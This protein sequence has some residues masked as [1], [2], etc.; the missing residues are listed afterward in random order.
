LN[1]AL[2]PTETPTS[3]LAEHSIISNMKSTLM[4]RY[5]TEFVTNIP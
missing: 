1:P 3:A 5:I 2:A 4:E